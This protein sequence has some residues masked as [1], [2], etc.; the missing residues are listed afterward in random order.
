MCCSPDHLELRARGGGGSGACLANLAPPLPPPPWFSF[1]PAHTQPCTPGTAKHF[2]PTHRPRPVSPTDTTPATRIRNTLPPLHTNAGPTAL[3]APPSQWQPGPAAL[4]AAP[5]PRTLHCCPARAPT[6]SCPWLPA[7]LQPRPTPSAPER[8][9]R[10]LRKAPAPGPTRR[11]RPAGA[12]R[13]RSR[14][15]TRRR[16]RGWAPEA[17]QWRCQPG[18]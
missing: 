13:S 18:P 8:L 5:P 9:L 6:T 4:A 1:L 2:D 12:L 16:V 7:P 15:A 3:L 10:R 17:R 11:K 14:G